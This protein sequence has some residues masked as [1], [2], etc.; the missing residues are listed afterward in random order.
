MAKALVAV[1]LG[2]ILVAGVAA[3]TGRNLLQDKKDGKKDEVT[4]DCDGA[5]RISSVNNACNLLCQCA[6]T[7][8]KS[9]SGDKKDKEVK[10]CKNQCEG[11]ASAAKNCKGKDL[12]KECKEGQ[13]NQYVKQ[14][15]TTYLKSQSG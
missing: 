14:C 9:L 13:D 15:I 10:R 1:V 6:G 11:C 2:A 12:P 7:L 3:E 5:K 8:D 4:F